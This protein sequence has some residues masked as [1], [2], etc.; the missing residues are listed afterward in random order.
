MVGSGIVL[1]DHVG[2]ASTPVRRLRGLLGRSR[3]E[4]GRGLLLEPASQ[5]HTLGMKYPIDVLFC[6]AE[7]EVVHL[8]RSMRP[9]RMSKWVRGARRALEL[10]AGS[11]PEEVAVGSKLVFY[12]GFSKGQ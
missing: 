6:D 4:P 1:A 5:V 11:V 2:V 7:N 10:P 8:I 9:T 12:E 3:L